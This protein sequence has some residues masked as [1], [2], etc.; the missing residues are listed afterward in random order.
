MNGC[1][2]ESDSMN[3]NHYWKKKEKLVQNK[4]IEEWVTRFLM[5]QLLQQTLDES[6]VDGISVL[7]TLRGEDGQMLTSW[8]TRTMGY[9]RRR[10]G[11]TGIQEEEIC[12]C[13]RD[14]FRFR[15]N[16][17]GDRTAV[18]KNFLLRICILNNEYL[19]MV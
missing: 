11:A 9:E 12:L 3:K 5:N 19:G 18:I 1:Q 14:K 7:T 15:M 16:S 6:D 10:V 17:Q 2:N 13:I 8:W 4:V